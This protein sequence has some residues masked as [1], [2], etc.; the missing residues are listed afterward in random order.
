MRAHVKVTNPGPIPRAALGLALL[1]AACGRTDGGSSSSDTGASPS[2]EAP[3]GA[4]RASAAVRMTR[5]TPEQVSRILDS[6]LNVQLGWK[7]GHGRFKD[8][9]REIYGVPLGGV[10]FATTFER[11]PSPKIHTIL[12]SRSLAWNVAAAFAW[13][14]SDPKAAGKE[15]RRR[16]LTK[17]DPRTDFPLEAAGSF[18]WVKDVAAR[19]AKWRSQLEDL[20]W[21]LLA[22]P[23][24][25]EETKACAQAFAKAV[26][27][28]PYPPLGWQIVVYGLLSTAEFWNVWGEK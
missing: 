13:W 23:P 17:A 18:P 3:G 14:E 27:A 1:V 22:R 5:L 25:P 20:Y 24:R 9:I 10:D 21:R 2:R 11:D 16:I 7:D 19:D 4:D 26:R 28:Q 6:R 15:T 12:V 8:A